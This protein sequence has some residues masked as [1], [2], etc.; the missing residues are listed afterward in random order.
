M[1]TLHSLAAAA[2]VALAA[3]SLSTPARADTEYPWCSITSTG[4]SG[5]PTCR[6]ATIEQCNAVLAGQSGF[7]QRNPRATANAEAMRRTAR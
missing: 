7:C 5:M 3:A 2:V 6:Y 1:K 4:Q